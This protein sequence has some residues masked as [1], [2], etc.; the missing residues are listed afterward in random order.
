MT[1]VGLDHL[2][3]R[4]H[5]SADWR[6][7]LSGGEQQSAALAGALLRPPRILLLDEPVS[8]LDEA[9]ASQL[10]AR[11]V[12]RLPNTTII[13]IGRRTVIGPWHSQIIELKPHTTNEGQFPIPVPA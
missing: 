4:L 7:E 11:L 8:A 6:A 10:F 1:V 2:I 5:E 9:A 3:G 13:S 12:E